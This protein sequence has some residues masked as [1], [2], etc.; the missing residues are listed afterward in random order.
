MTFRDSERVNLKPAGALFLQVEQ[1]RHDSVSNASHVGATDTRTSVCST[2]PVLKRPYLAG[3]KRSL[4]LQGSAR[5][6]RRILRSSG[7][8]ATLRIWADDNLHGLGRCHFEGS[9]VSV[10]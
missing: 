1:V 7:W 9:G 4:T 10:Q 6:L 5:T 2:G 8:V 3:S